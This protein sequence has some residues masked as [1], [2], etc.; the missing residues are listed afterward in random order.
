MAMVKDSIGDKFD[1]FAENFK[2]NP[3]TSTSED[4][5]A[6]DF[7]NDKKTLHEFMLLNGVCYDDTSVISDPGG[8]VA[9]AFPARALIVWEAIADNLANK[10]VAD[11]AGKAVPKGKSGADFWGGS[12]KTG[13]RNPAAPVVNQSPVLM[14]PESKWVD[15]T[16]ELIVNW[17]KDNYNFACT[18]YNDKIDAGETD[19][20]IK[21]QKEIET[22]PPETNN[23]KIANKFNNYYKGAKFGAAGVSLPAL[24]TNKMKQ[25]PPPSYMPFC[26]PHKDAEGTKTEANG[27]KEGPEGYCVGP[28]VKNLPIIP[29]MSGGD[30]KT[31]TVKDPNN[32]N[33]IEEIPVFRTQVSPT[34]Q[35]EFLID[36]EYYQD[37][38]KNQLGSSNYE[39]FRTN[40]AAILGADKDTYSELPID[41]KQLR[42]SNGQPIL[43]NGKPIYN[44]DRRGK[45]ITEATNGSGLTNPNFGEVID[46]PT[47]GQPVMNT[48]LDVKD[49]V[50][51]SNNPLVF[52]SEADK[53]LR[54]TNNRF[55]NS[56]IGKYGSK[57]EPVKCYFPYQVTNIDANKRKVDGLE[58]SLTDP[59]TWG[60]I[61]YTGNRKRGDATAEDKAEG[62]DKLAYKFVVPGSTFNSL[63]TANVDTSR[64]NP[65]YEQNILPEINKQYWG[66]RVLEAFPKAKTL[67]EAIGEA[68][69]PPKTDSAG[70]AVVVAGAGGVYKPNA[71]ILMVG[72][73]APP[74]NV[75]EGGS[76]KRTFE[77]S[78]TVCLWKDGKL[79]GRPG[80][81]FDRGAEPG[82]AAARRKFSENFVNMYGKIDDKIS[83]TA[84][85]GMTFFDVKKQ[86]IPPYTPP[87]LKPPM[88]NSATFKF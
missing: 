8:R 47:F 35:N 64:R 48:E 34:D 26:K 41:G 3:K 32:R 59:R 54:W 12:A 69:E 24:I 62:F 13:V 88:P 17:F 11:R 76:A 40:V 77:W 86:I 73:P 51:P 10:F 25:T 63:Q 55:R 46:D 4:L 28:I 50:N 82:N 37:E 16:K 65:F 87:P 45:G 49:W 42:G 79:K 1:K 68:L 43:N 70:T 29:K 78:N 27:S 23:Q 67:Q 39:T 58:L 44:L 18:E 33:I 52:Q 85:G 5:A 75:T 84:R 14:Q 30:Q 22:T 20:K 66:L 74:F 38:I 56:Q 31:T 15:N 80:V 61:E 7:T 19:G 9:D 83:G 71:G 6:F 57:F 36:N 81:V 53:T 21:P 60:W 72:G 2:G